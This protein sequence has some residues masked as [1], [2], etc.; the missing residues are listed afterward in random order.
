MA[1]KILDFD[2]TQFFSS[3]NRAGNTQHTHY[4][5]EALLY[6][7]RPRAVRTFLCRYFLSKKSLEC[8]KF[9]HIEF[10]VIWKNIW[11]MEGSKSG[12]NQIWIQDDSWA[13]DE[14]NFIHSKAPEPNIGFAYTTCLTQ[15]VPSKWWK[16]DFLALYW[17][18][19]P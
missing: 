3:P 13:R 14:Y 7:H 11:C 1:V 10:L 4:Q 8:P 16:L 2:W 15:P 19:L 12:T 5:V 17:Q 6:T 18:N 9:R